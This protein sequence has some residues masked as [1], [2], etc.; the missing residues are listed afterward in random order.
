MQR[1]IIQGDHSDEVTDVQSRL[2]DLGFEIN[3]EPGRF[4]PSTFRAVRAFQ[5]R[6]YLLVDGI[7]GPQTWN[8]IVEAS[9]HLGDRTLYLKRPFMRG[10]DVVALQQRLNALGFD[11]GRQDGIFGPLAYAAVRAFQREYGIAEDGM[12]G[13]RTNAALAGL[14]VDRPGIPARIREELRHRHGRGLAGEMIVIDPGHGGD[15]RGVLGPSGVAEADVCWTLATLVAAALAG[16]GARVRLSRT[17]PEDPSEEQRA[18]RANEMDA[19]LVISIHMNSNPEPT[20]EGSS[21]YHWVTSTAGEQLA[22][23]IQHEVVSHTGCRDCRTHPR[24]YTILR[25]TKAPAVMIEPAF[26]TNPDEAKLLDD[27]DHLTAL[28]D[29]IVRGVRR[30]AEVGMR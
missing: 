22:D 26:I 24:S 13:P 28:A 8:A 18:E 12:F 19:D 4:G 9:W 15:D 16:A 10:D 30:W 25:E 11:A 5:Q 20:A 2:R 21:I 3:D 27:R 29:A 23:A 1:L 17:E 14:R 6:R 7:V